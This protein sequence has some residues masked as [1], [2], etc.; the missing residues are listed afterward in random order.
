MSNTR[1][2]RVD[3][4]NYEGCYQTS[5]KGRVRS[6]EREVTSG[7]ITR[8]QSE[9]IFVHWR[10]KTSLHDRVRLYK[11]GIGEKFS[12]HRLVAGY[13]LS[14]WDP[15]L[16]V[17]HIDGNRYNN[18]AENLEM[19]T[20][21][22]DMEH[23]IANDLKNDHGEK[24]RNAKLTNAQAE[25]IRERYHAGGITQLELAIGFGVSHQTVSCI[26]RHKKYIR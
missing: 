22:R 8:T 16:E 23:A 19:C 7:G 18:A 15:A 25:R 11:N 4:K 1:E 21:Q 14:D 26:V 17:N 10:G 20:H 3:I 24:S 9:R 6:L 2:I 5:N 12:V 13:F